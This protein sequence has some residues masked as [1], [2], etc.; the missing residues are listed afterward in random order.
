MK[1]KADGFSR[2][3]GIFQ[4]SGE[5]HRK[6]NPDVADPKDLQTNQAHVA[7][8]TVYSCGIRGQ[9][10]QR[11]GFCIDRPAQFPADADAVSGWISHHVKRTTT[12]P[13]R[14]RV[15]LSL[16][17]LLLRQFGFD[18]RNHSVKRILRHFIH[19]FGRDKAMLLFYT[20]FRQRIDQLVPD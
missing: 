20:P 5:S 12:I 1:L 6:P 13:A 11:A 16:L 15:W 9:E 8:L 7:G 14:C 3:S 4:K 18:E 2:I 17:F 19:P 10:R